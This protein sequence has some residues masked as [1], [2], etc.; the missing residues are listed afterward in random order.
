VQSLGENASKV[1]LTLLTALGV[2]QPS[3]GRGAAH[4]TDQLGEILT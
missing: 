3:Y 2:P 1:P 4:T